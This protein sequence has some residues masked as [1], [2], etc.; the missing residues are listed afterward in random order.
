[1]THQWCKQH[2]QCHSAKDV[3][4]WLEFKAQLRTVLLG[5]RKVAQS[6]GTQNDRTFAPQLS[7]YFLLSQRHVSWGSSLEIQLLSWQTLALESP[8]SWD[9]VRVTF[10]LWLALETHRL[11]PGLLSLIHAYYILHP[12]C[13]LAGWCQ[14]CLLLGIL[15][16]L[17]DWLEFKATN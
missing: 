9:R 7:W 6:W 16:V 5:Q 15:K 14:V 1:M 11:P 13:L 10:L 2:H 12:A 8:G 4:G 17:G 3:D